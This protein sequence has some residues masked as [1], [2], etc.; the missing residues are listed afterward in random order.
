[1]NFTVVIRLNASDPVGATCPRGFDFEKSID[2]IGGNLSHLLA[3]FVEVRVQSPTLESDPS[4]MESFPG[5]GPGQGTAPG[6]VEL[7]FGLFLWRC[8]SQLTVG[9]GLQF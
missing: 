1:M 6:R 7:I 4:Q 9:T 2:G 8:H 3:V 5:Q